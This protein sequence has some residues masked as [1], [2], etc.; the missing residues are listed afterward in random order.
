MKK[1]ILFIIVFAVISSCTI[2]DIAVDKGQ[3][4]PLPVF[5]AGMESVPETRTYLDGNQKQLWMAGDDISVFF[6]TT[7]NKKYSFIGNTG[8][9][10]GD[11]EYTGDS[12]SEDSE[13][14]IYTNYAIYPYDDNASISSDGTICLNLPGVQSYAENSFAPKSNTMVA[15]TSGS[16]DYFLP[17]KNVCGYIVVRMYGEDIVKNISLT[18]NNGEQIAGPAYVMARTGQ[19]PILEMDGEASHTIW[20]DCGSGVNLNPSQD[21]PTE[22]WFCVPPTVFSEGFNISATNA[23]GWSMSRS[24]TSSRTV[25]RNVFYM[26]QPIQ[27][28]FDIAPVKGNAILPAGPVFNAYL[29]GI[30]VSQYTAGGTVDIEALKYYVNVN[31]PSVRDIVFQNNSS[32]TDGIEIQDARSEF[33]IYLDRSEASGLVVISTPADQFATGEDASM[34]FYGCTA[35]ERITNLS[36][37]NTEAATDMYCMFAS[38]YALTTLDLSSFDFANNTTMMKAFAY[39]SSL[40]QILWPE[41]IDMANLQDIGYCFRGTKLS[42][43]DLSKWRNL[44]N[45]TSTAYVFADCPNC[46]KV[47]FPDDVDFSSIA[48]CSD[49][50][51]HSSENLKL[52]CTGINVE[53]LPMLNYM[54]SGCRAS[55]IDCTGWNTENT[56]SQTYLFYNCLNLHTLRLGDGF[57]GTNCTGS[58][59]CFFAG[60]TNKPTGDGALTQTGIVPGYV[61][62]YCSEEVMEWVSNRA[63]VKYVNDGYYNG[64]PCPVRFFDW[65]TGEEYYPWYYAEYV[66]LGLSVKW[67]TCNLGADTPEQ[68]GGYYQ[69][70]GLEDVTSTSI[71][72][73]WSNCPYHTG[74]DNKTGWTKYVPS[75]QSSYWSGTGSPDNKTVLDPEDDVA[76][77]KL[78]GKWRMPTEAEWSE[79]ADDCTWT[80]T[81]QN[82]VDGYNVTSNKNGNSIFLPAAGHREGTD[83]FEAGSLGIY[84]SSSLWY[85]PDSARYLSFYSDRVNVVN[86]IFARLHGLSVRP[87]SEY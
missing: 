81:T 83:L 15:V 5:S 75:N 76:H 52:D 21:N 74:S 53:T 84:W 61:D 33:P 37:L 72:L 28:S 47:V 30:D 50:F 67:A 57:L 39:D 20:I 26:M 12:S 7:A 73:D 36:A 54:F 87:V 27:A 46:S 69:W 4:I 51:Y 32:C 80:W 40:V 44:Q 42:L 22:F 60:I 34:L 3:D 6:E 63:T 45:L 35:M 17:F 68:Y 49:W 24:V 43:Y 48:S 85:A 41:E 70:G 59:L 9:T 16:D 10:S 86:W 29:K 64:I 23:E 13:S 1:I 66:D 19:N 62:I 14:T 31:D 18:G 8:D 71:Y 11:F 56:V 79:L 2:N 78:G 65:K 77:V 55:E 25:E 82:G 58:T 38:D